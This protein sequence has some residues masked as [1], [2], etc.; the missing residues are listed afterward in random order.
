[1]IPTDPLP[2]PND[3][4]FSYIMEDSDGS[5]A[6]TFNWTP[7]ILNCPSLQYIITSNCGSCPNMTMITTVTCRGIEFGKRCTFEISSA[8][9]GSI[10]GNTSAILV[11]LK[12]IRRSIRTL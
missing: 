10:I 7:V 6:L 9:C 1:M 5:M 3:V 12:G 4:T 2:P 11:D 8:V